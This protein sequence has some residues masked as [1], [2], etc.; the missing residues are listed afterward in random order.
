MRL[1]RRLERF[2]GC[3]SESPISTTWD[4][5]FPFCRPGGFER[6][7]QL[8]LQV[9]NAGVKYYREGTN[10]KVNL[11]V[12]FRGQYYF[13]IQCMGEAHFIIAVWAFKGQIR[14]NVIR[15][16]DVIENLKIQKHEPKTVVHT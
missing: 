12:F 14:D 11:C 8:P 9:G 3:A 5:C 6:P 4:R 1:R 7:T 10:I 15:Q 2:L 13:L 16:S